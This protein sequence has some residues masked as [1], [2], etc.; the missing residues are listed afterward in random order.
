MIDHSISR[1]Y[2][3]WGA[4]ETIEHWAALCHLLP[5]TVFDAGTIDTRC[6]SG[7]LLLSVETQET[8]EQE[9]LVSHGVNEGR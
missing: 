5:C 6:L 2:H 3:V 8:R 4:I 9:R 7:V 1:E